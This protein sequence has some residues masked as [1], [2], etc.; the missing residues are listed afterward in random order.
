MSFGPRSRPTFRPE[1]DM[2]A[3]VSLRALADELE[4]LGDGMHAFVNRHTGEVYSSTTE[5]LGLAEEGDDEPVLDWEGA[6]V[7]KLR[8][9]LGSADWLAV[10]TPDSHEDYRV[11]ERFCLE[12]C[13][14]RLQ[15]E[16]LS[17]ISG[18]GAFGRFKD[19]IHRR[20]VQDAWYRFRREALAEDAAAWLE[21]HEIPYG[22]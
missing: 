9:I 18:R 2:A 12:R 3:V 8:E 19:G 7:A 16:L 17:A 14:G 1:C 6:I 5:L 21:A 10:P 15:E 4:I 20:G 22:P 13:E 11:M